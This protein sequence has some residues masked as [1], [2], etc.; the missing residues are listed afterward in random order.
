MLVFKLLTYILLG[1]VV[2]C[3]VRESLMITIT[4]TAEC[5]NADIVKIV[6]I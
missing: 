2:I 6:N 3:T 4:F 5:A 1:S